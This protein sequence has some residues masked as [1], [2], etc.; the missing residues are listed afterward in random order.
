MKNLQ[1]IQISADSADSLY[2]MNLQNRQK[3]EKTLYFLL[4]YTR[5]DDS[6]TEL[7]LVLMKISSELNQASF[8][9]ER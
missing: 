7:K 5:L 6:L 4:T 1:E 9:L 8:L 2:T 3:V